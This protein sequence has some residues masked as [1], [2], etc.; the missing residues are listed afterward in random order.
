MSHGAD[1]KKPDGTAPPSAL[2]RRDFE[3]LA[4][5]G[6]LS[7]L[8]AHCA[9]ERFSRPAP[10]DVT[11]RASRSTEVDYVVIGSGAGGGPVACNL[12][13]AGYT[14][15]LLEAGGDPAASWTRDVPALHPAA[16]EDPELR[17]DFF[18]RTYEREEQLRRNPRFV[19]ARGGI[20]YPRAGTLGGCTAHNAMITLCPHNSDWDAIAATFDDA[21]WSAENMR[22]YFERLEHCDY[23][24]ASQASGHGDRGWLHTELADV[25]L[26]LRD[27]Q[28]R[29]IVEAALDEAAV[30]D[31][32]LYGDALRMAL[33]PGRSLWDPNDWRAVSAAAEGMVFVPLH[34]NRGTRTGTREYVRAVM[35]RCQGNLRLELDALV[36][37]VLFDAD[38]RAVGV[39][40]FSGPRLY[41]ASAYPA[42]G[43]EAGERREIRVR[44][45][46]VLAAGVFNSP[47]ILMLSGIGPRAEL[48]RHGIAPL[49]DLP[50]V[51]Q[52]LQDRYEIS[53]VSELAAE[54]D[55]ARGATLRPPSPEA[56]D[57]SL[58]RWWFDR[59]GPYAT[60]GVVGALVKKSRPALATPDLFVFGVVGDFHGY[61]PGYSRDL[62]ADHRHFTW[63]VLKAHTQ[64]RAGYVRLRSPDPRDPPE[65]CF[66]YFDEGSPGADEDLAAVVDGVATARR[67]MAR[68]GSEVREVRPGP[69]VQQPEDVAR[70][71]RDSAWGHHASCSNK[72][73]PASDPLAVVDQHFRVHG[74]HGLRVVDASVFPRIPGFFV[75][76]PVFMI[77]E[78]ASDAL[79]A[80]AA[81][82]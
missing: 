36:S 29:H 71:V 42:S 54:L 64:N 6:A 10:I 8:A 21:S 56:P 58:R 68:L 55:V 69:Q 78:K 20:L 49:V 3:K 45:E 11:C 2:T 38:R 60:N 24:P 30:L 7:S 67:I 53:V 57:P 43:A 26:A 9:G 46:V 28:L 13:R 39:E 25:W 17:W 15:A 76:V 75:V 27:S 51:G 65:V 31:P 44:R 32:H 5:A 16:S 70:F 35:A 41:R 79:L 72:M 33:S 40:Y 47:Q 34:M 19:P 4:L 37:R 61:Y 74:T 73:G 77:A 48:E 14:V 82:T 18:V 1:R 12:A 81:G 59:T 63:T 80:D 62:V 66:R 22:R 52:N 23:A 50:G